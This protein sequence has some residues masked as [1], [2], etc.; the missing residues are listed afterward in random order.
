VGSQLFILK[1]LSSNKNF[2]GLSYK[3]FPDTKEAVRL[4]VKK[5]SALIYGDEQG[6]SIEI[7]IIDE[8]N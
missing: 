2:Y 5:G 3:G 1:S 6:V 7:Y 4:I 8:Q